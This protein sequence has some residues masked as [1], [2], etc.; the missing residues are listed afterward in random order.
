MTDTLDHI[1]KLQHDIW[2]AK[3]D[4]QK[5]YIHLIENEAIYLNWLNADPERKRRVLEN[6][7]KG[8]VEK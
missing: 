3:T 5:L 4:E 7:K 2:M 6:A 1:K 8:I